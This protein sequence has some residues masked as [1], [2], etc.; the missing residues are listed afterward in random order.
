MMRGDRLRVLIVE[1]SEQDTL[2][3]VRMLRHGGYEPV[4]ER[5]A[6]ST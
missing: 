6:G 3:L 5:G 2:L 4:V 1:D